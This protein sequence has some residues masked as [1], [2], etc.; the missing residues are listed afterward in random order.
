[1]Q[2]VCLPAIPLPPPFFPSSNSLGEEKK[3]SRRLILAIVLAQ[4]SIYR[5]KKLMFYWSLLRVSQ[6]RIRG[7]GELG[8]PPVLRSSPRRP[9][10]P[11]LATSPLNYICLLR[12]KLQILKWHITISVTS[13]NRGRLYIK[14]FYKSRES[15]RC[16]FFSSEDQSSGAYGR[17][18]V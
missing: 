4:F 5:D 9:S 14:D 16:K 2:I 8:S 11:I 3:I 15:V 12:P 10:V 1:M 18:G 17:T 6:S 7:R 13:S